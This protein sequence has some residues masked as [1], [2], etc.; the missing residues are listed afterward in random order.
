MRNKKDLK[1]WQDVGELVKEIFLSTE[2]CSCN[3]IIELMEEEEDWGKHQPCHYCQL[4]AVIK[5]TLLNYYEKSIK[6]ADVVEVLMEYNI[7]N[8]EIIEAIE[9]VDQLKKE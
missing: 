2:K 3:L 4:I 5:H 1:Y 9:A 8:L 6:R 7:Q